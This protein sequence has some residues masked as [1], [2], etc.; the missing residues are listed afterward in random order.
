MSSQELNLLF[1]HVWIAVGFC[2]I[3]VGRIQLVT[4]M[5]EAMNQQVDQGL[6]KEIQAEDELMQQEG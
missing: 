4:F 5:A 3:R 2:S 6:L 1:P